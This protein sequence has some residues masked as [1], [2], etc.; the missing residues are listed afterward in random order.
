M[1]TLS[2]QPT[3]KRH[4]HEISSE[5][6]WIHSSPHKF[7]TLAS[8]APPKVD[9]LPQSCV[10]FHLQQLQTSITLYTTPHPPPI[11]R[12]AQT[13]FFLTSLGKASGNSPNSSVKLTLILCI[14]S[15]TAVLISFNLISSGKSLNNLVASNSLFERPALRIF[16]CSSKVKF[17]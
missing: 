2:L 10:L 7:E 8:E 13:Q 15:S 17:L 14:Q 6:D 12:Y 1:T 3:N 4:N 9:D 5:V 16:D 11:I